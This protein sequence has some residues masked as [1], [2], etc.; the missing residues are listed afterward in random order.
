MFQNKKPFLFGDLVMIRL[1]KS[2][3]KFMIQQNLEFMYLRRK[4]LLNK[5]KSKTIVVQKIF[6]ENYKV[7]IFRDGTG[8]V[9][10]LSRELTK[11]ANNNINMILLFNMSKCPNINQLFHFLKKYN[12]NLQILSKI[13]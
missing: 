10:R 9:S 4:N 13:I 5:K 1:P 8:G 6:M 3:K 7:N 11:Y 12:Q 2:F